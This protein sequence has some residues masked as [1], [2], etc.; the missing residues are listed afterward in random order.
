M[1]LFLLLLAESTR[2]VVL[3]ALVAVGLRVARGV[4]EW[5]GLGRVFWG[6]LGKN[7]ARALWL[8][9]DADLMALLAASIGTEASR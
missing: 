1:A 2:S 3:P 7:E 4:I 5:C 6:A 8:A 9:D